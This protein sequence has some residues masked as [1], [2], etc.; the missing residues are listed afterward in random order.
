[1]KVMTVAFAALLGFQ[2]AAFAQT[3]S[4]QSV[5][6]AAWLSQIPLGH[7]FK[8]NDEL[9][10]QYPDNGP[11]CGADHAELEWG[12]ALHSLRYLCVPESANGS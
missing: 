8:A 1:M 9:R 10:R 4:N 11:S 6:D 12:P 2:A 7:G 5:P 3:W